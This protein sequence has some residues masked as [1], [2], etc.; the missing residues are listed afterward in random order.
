MVAMVQPA[1]LQR[2]CD[3]VLERPDL[4]TPEIVKRTPP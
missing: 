1:Q 3:D 2:L 4:R